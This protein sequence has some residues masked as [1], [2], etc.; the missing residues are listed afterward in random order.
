MTLEFEEL[1]PKI[2]V[3][4]NPWS[5]IDLVT[6]TI[7][8][9]EKNPEGSILSE[10]KQWYTFGK[11]V[12][13]LEYQDKPDDERT[14]REKAVWDE[15]IDVF[16]KT[17]QHYSEHHGLPI[18]KDKFVYNEM[19]NGDVELWKR[20]GPSICK[21]EEASGIDEPLFD[22]SM[23]VHTDYQVEYVD[24][25]GYKFVLTCTMYLNDDYDGG[26]LEFLVGGNKLFYYKPKKGDVLLFPA[27]DPNYLSD[28][29]ELYMH[30]VKKCYRSPKYFIRNHW[31]RF[32]PGTEEWQANEKIYGKEAWAEMELQRVKDGRKNGAYQSID[33]A[34]V[35]A[36][37]ERIK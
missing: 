14:R 15:V 23:H 13:M 36:E 26:G 19:E 7:I 27:G 4:R 20:M 21:Y 9:S 35:L 34:K 16:Y 5:N 8:E 11:E 1:Y 22:L 10:W 2:F 25:R 33:Y 37:A 32:F 28:D 18:E 31:T 12:N 30:G 29:N 17:T 24:N 3:Y 6:N